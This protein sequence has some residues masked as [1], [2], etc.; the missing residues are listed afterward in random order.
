MTAEPVTI[1][2]GSVKFNPSL[3]VLNHYY[4][5]GLHGKPYLYRRVSDRE[6]EVYGLAHKPTARSS[7]SR[8]A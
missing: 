1:D 7:F 3:M 8:R 2:G 6:V 5:V 4:C